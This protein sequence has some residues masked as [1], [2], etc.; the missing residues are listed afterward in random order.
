MKTGMLVYML[1]VAKLQ[2][3]HQKCQFLNLK[4]KLVENVT[5]K[6]KAY[7]IMALTSNIH[8]SLRDQICATKQMPS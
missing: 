8:I 5:R 4:K 7:N 6:Y 1:P 2:K 3:F